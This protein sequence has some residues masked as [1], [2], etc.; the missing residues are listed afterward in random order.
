MGGGLG[1]LKILV[2]YDDKA[3]TEDA[4]NFKIRQIEWGGVGGFGRNILKYDNCE[5]TRKELI[6]KLFGGKIVPNSSTIGTNNRI[7]STTMVDAKRV[8]DEIQKVSNHEF[9]QNMIKE[10]T[11]I[12]NEHIRNGNIGNLAADLLPLLGLKKREEKILTDIIERR[13]KHTNI[14][15]NNSDVVSKFPSTNS[16]SFPTNNPTI[17]PTTNS[18]T[19]I[20]NEPMSE[21]FKENFML[22]MA[23]KM[24][25]ENDDAE[26]GDN[27]SVGVGVGVMGNPDAIYYEE[28][29]PES[30]KVLDKVFFIGAAPHYTD[31]VFNYIETMSKHC[32]DRA[33][34][35][36]LKMIFNCLHKHRN[37]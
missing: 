18:T 29:S 34:K 17:N 23:L 2:D 31:E 32:L 9:T 33:G 16:L 22:A 13:L 10:G 11:N 14:I 8:L 15:T 26:I 36:S 1:T 27:S 25:D 21:G 30:N 4:I 19:T 24:F 35:I 37:T 12:I 5:K 7:P 3:E 6:T 28:A 20:L